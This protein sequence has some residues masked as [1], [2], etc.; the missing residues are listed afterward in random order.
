MEKMEDKRGG[1]I[2]ITQGKFTTDS[3][4]DIS[5][6]S[7]SSM[8]YQEWIEGKCVEEMVVQKISIE[9]VIS[10]YEFNLTEEQKTK[11]RNYGK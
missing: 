11:L 4:K 7:N 3:V 6:L 1:G 5:T 9:D 8:A 2:I 10:K